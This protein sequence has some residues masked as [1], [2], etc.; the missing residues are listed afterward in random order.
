MAF[1]FGSRLVTNRPFTD[2]LREVV[3]HFQVIE[4]QTDPRYFSPNFSFTINEKKALRIYQEQYGFHLTMHAPYVNLRLGAINIEERQI[5]IN[6]FLNAMRLTS[7]LGIN[8]LTFHPCTLEPNAPELYP[9]NCLFEEGSISLLLTEAKKMGITLLIENM[10]RMPEYH[11]KTAD[12]SRF[13][14]LLWLFPEPEFGITLDLGHALQA[15]IT[16][17]SLLKMERI[18][19]F[20]FHENDRNADLHSP[21]NTNIEWWSKALKTITKQFPNAFGILEM[22]RLEEQIESLNQLAPNSKKNQRPKTQSNRLIPPLL[23]L[24]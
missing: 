6:I 17:E 15:G 23:D 21:I 4:L 12:G 2:Y 19:H 16:L 1:R 13:Q 11:P 8:T 20:H 5:S 18:Q 9:E 7:D 10:P 14:E 24:E 3:H 22:V